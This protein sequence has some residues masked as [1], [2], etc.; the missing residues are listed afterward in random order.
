MAFWR[1]GCLPFARLLLVACHSLCCSLRGVEHLISAYIGLPSSVLLYP[2]V[3]ILSRLISRFSL[4]YVHRSA[5]LSQLHDFISYAINHYVCTVYLASYVSGE[6]EC[7]VYQSRQYLSPDLRVAQ[8]L[9]NP[10]YICS[11][12]CYQLAL[13]PLI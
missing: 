6:K 9:C 1:C 3:S 7:A 10:G 11:G 4:A 8:A 13:L 2:V 12:I 5:I